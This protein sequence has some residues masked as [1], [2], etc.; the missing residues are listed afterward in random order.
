MISNITTTFLK[1]EKAFNQEKYREATKLLNEVIDHDR[2]F[3]S[4]YLLLYEIYN[5]KKSQQKNMI[6]KE[7]KRLNLDLEIDHKPITIKTKKNITNPKLVTLSL[8][9]LMIAQGK[10]SQAK[11]N[12]RLII[13]YSK[14]KKNIIRAEEML[15]SL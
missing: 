8:I 6:Y 2:D 4:A 9:K 13:K 3:Y 10:K 1:A 5:N 11:K 12:L 7:L 14:I 15:K